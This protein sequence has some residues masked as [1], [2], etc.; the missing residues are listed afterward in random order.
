MGALTAGV[1]LLA[2]LVSFMPTNY[3]W[4]NSMPDY[5]D[6]TMVMVT[7]VASGFAA[8]LTV[9]ATAFFWRSKALVLTLS[10]PLAVDI[11]RLITLLP[12]Y[13]G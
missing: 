10:L 12:H 7:T 8:V 11:Y 2:M 6:V 13:E 4:D 3:D 5:S 9:A 1:G